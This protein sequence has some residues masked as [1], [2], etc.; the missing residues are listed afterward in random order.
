ML[1]QEVELLRDE[2]FLYASLNRKDVKVV[3]NILS[4]DVTIEVGVVRSYTEAY[5]KINDCYF[6]RNS[7]KFVIE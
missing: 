3:R 4:K 1:S 5:I 7:N 6:I 2:D